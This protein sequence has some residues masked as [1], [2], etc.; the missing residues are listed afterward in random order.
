MNEHKCK[1][2]KRAF[3]SSIK[4]R[5]SHENECDQS[6]VAVCREHVKDDT[7]AFPPLKESEKLKEIQCKNDSDKTD[8]DHVPQP[9]PSNF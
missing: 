3:Y 1:K 4:H 7:K 6:C 9:S 2:C 8:D 5:K